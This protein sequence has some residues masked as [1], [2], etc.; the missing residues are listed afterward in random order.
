VLVGHSQGAAAALVVAEEHPERVEGVVLV[1]PELDGRGAP[2]WFKPVMLTPQMRRLGPYLMDWG[3]ALLGERALER[4]WHDPSRIPD[5]RMSAY[6]DGMEVESWGA[7]MWEHS[8]APFTYGLAGRA[9][10]LDVPVLI[11]AGD[12]DRVVGTET[13]RELGR[14]L[15]DAT[16]FE[17]EQCGHIPQEECPDE[18]V[19]AVQSFVDSL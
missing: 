19:E 6:V 7:G 1:A 3:A 15:P 2:S 10:A 4:A 13:L 14:A 17:I 12:D 16:Y 8:A 9:Q 18:F 5:E 11:V